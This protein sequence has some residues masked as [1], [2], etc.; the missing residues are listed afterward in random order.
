[1]HCYFPLMRTLIAGFTQCDVGLTMGKLYGND[2]SQTTISRFEALN[3]SFKNMCKLKPLLEKWLSDVDGGES[4]STVVLGAVS[5]TGG[6]VSSVSDRPMIVRPAATLAFDTVASR[7][8]KKRTNIDQL[9][10]QALET[11]FVASPKPSAEQISDMANRLGMDRD[12]VQ[13]W[14]CNRRQKE[15]RVH[16]R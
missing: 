9:L 16:P 11:L 10:R 2:F 12:V 15:K 6:G 7:R 13:V 5:A 4:A 1:M 14:F 3:L 8:R